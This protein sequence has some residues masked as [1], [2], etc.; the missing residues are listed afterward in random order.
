MEEWKCFEVVR[1]C[2]LTE[3]TVKSDVFLT[4]VVMSHSLFFLPRYGYL[5]L[6]ESK[7]NIII[8][9]VIC[10]LLFLIYCI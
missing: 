6:F 10:V 5:A 2:V 8:Q 4:L 9:V 3:V 1:V 7:N